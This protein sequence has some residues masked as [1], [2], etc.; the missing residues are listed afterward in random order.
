MAALGISSGV[1]GL[2]S[3]GMT[4]CQGL[5]D[6]YDSWRDARNHVEKMYNSIQALSKTLKLLES[7]IL[8]Q[9]FDPDVVRRVEDCIR[10]VEKGLQSLR[11]KLDKLHLVPVQKEWQAKAISQFRRT[12]FPFKESTL[13]KLKELGN[14]LRD[15]LSL[16]LNL[17]HI[18]SSTA[19]LKRLDLIGQTLTDV[20]TNVDGLKERS[21]SIS[22][23]LKDVQVSTMTTSRS[24]SGLVSSQTND[25]MRRVYDWLSPLTTEFQR[26]QQDTFNIQSRQDGTAQWFLEASEFKTWLSGSGSTLWCP[27]IRE[28]LSFMN[29]QWS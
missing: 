17:L 11:K 8:N 5:L 23:S 29:L 2:I 20:S 27:G 13:V 24:V 28:S 1:A 21:I 26:K 4:V 6:Y 22:D 3:L 15:D 10:S 9:A 25:H 12:L 16:A 14:E 7:A 18:D 19:A